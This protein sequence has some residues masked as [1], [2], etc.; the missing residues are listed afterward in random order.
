MGSASVLILRP[1]P[2]FK[3]VFEQCEGSVSFLRFEL[4]IS[5]KA[6]SLDGCPT[7]EHG[8]FSG[9][10]VVSEQALLRRRRVLVAIKFSFYLT[11]T[12]CN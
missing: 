11:V 1:G 4:L 8:R 3:V 5:L 12:I 2:A 6:M 9:K 7:S 10:S